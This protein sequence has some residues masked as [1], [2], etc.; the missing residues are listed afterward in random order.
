MVCEVSQV[1]HPTLT[2]HKVDNG[3][4]HTTLVKP[5]LS[6]LNK[7]LEGLSKSRALDSLPRTRSLAVQQYLVGVCRRGFQQF[8][9]RLV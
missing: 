1:H 6:V 3:L 2:L 7:L 5:I 9:W 4:S 8:L